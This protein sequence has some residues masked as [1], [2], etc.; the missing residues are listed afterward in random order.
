MTEAE[1]TPAQVEDGET[2]ENEETEGI[3]APT[4]N[5]V[6]EQTKTQADQENEE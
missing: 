2:E 1:M 5:D 4:S 6:G 3:E